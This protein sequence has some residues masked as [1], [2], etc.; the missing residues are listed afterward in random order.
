MQISYEDSHQAFPVEGGSLAIDNIVF[1]YVLVTEREKR[2]RLGARVG[3]ARTASR[4][5]S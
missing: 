1:C 2:R 4:G 5:G 3:A